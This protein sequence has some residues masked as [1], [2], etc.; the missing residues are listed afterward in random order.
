M[1]FLFI[2]VLVIISRYRGAF[3]ERKL[4]HP[5]VFWVAS[6]VGMIACVWGA[7]VTFTN[8]WTPLV[9]RTDWWHVVLFLSVVSVAVA[10]VIWYLGR[11]AA[12][13]D[14]LPPEAR[15]VAS[16]ES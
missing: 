2:D 3:E 9:G 8:P 16:S 4:A 7:V 10:P 12:R 15:V 5:V 11:A 13:D 14:A 6:I 1:A